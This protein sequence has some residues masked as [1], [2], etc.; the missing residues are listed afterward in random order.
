MTAIS[1]HPARGPVFTPTEDDMAGRFAGV[2]VAHL[3]E[4]EELLAVTGE[5]LAAVRAAAAYEA[6]MTGETWPVSLTSPDLDPDEIADHAQVRHVTF[7][8]TDHHGWIVHPAAPD[9][10]GAVAVTW[11]DTSSLCDAAEQERPVPLT[12]HREQTIRDRFA[13]GGLTDSALGAHARRD[14]PILL[15]EIGQLRAQT[16]DSR[17]IEDALDDACQELEAQLEAATS[18]AQTAQARANETLRQVWHV[19]TTAPPAVSSPALAEN[20][21][22]TTNEGGER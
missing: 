10:P 8:R 11:L 5:V 1:E 18:R 4:P 16:S 20:T 3:D 6:Y 22:S 7:H 2:L 21:R 15:A 9:T 19:L 13:D 12:P 17:A 14:V